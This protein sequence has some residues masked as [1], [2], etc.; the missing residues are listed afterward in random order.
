MSIDLK[1]GVQGELSISG[2][3]QVSQVMPFTYLK[4]IF[5]ALL[6][7]FAIWN[8]R[9]KFSVRIAEWASTDTA[10]RCRKSH[11]LC[12]FCVLGCADYCRSNKRYILQR[13][14]CYRKGRVARI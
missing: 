1:F 13:M 14:F 5:N 7:E 12:G 8:I 10:V 4:I 11:V 6:Q 2:I 9:D 3:S